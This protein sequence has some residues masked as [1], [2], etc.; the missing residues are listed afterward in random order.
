M[1]YHWTNTVFCALFLKYQTIDATENKLKIAN[2]II[3][4]VFTILILNFAAAAA[5][6]AA[7]IAVLSWLWRIYE[8]LFRLK[9]CEY[10]NLSA[11]KLQF[12]D[13][14]AAKKCGDRSEKRSNKLAHT[15]T[16]NTRIHGRKERVRENG[17]AKET[18]N[19]Q[20]TFGLC[21]LRNKKI[22]PIHFKLLHILPLEY[23]YFLAQIQTIARA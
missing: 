9:Y 18:R 4:F 22:E 1:K 5:A 19:K 7:A 21:E 17:S 20:H 13:I 10:T 11:L 6:A 8:I 2:N 14:V 16:Q 23:Q 15:H 3:H 12:N